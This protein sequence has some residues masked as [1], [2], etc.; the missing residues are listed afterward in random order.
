MALEELK[1]SARAESRLGTSR[2]PYDWNAEPGEF[3]LGD[4]VEFSGFT[5][6]LRL[7]GWRVIARP[8]WVG[9]DELAELM[10]FALL[11]GREVMEG[12]SDG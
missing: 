10:A 12:L 2:G 11:H 3:I 6:Q 8:D 1:D 4:V 9:E 7:C 5:A